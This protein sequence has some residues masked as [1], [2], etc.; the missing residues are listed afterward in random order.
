MTGLGETARVR[1][2]EGYSPMLTGC[3]VSTHVPEE[4]GTHLGH[5]LSID[6]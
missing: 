4:L 6:H 5:T 3:Y 1:E 2:N